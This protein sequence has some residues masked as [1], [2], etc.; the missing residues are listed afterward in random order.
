MSQCDYFAI[1]NRGCLPC[2]WLHPLKD[3]EQDRVPRWRGHV[4]PAR[5][6]W[7]AVQKHRP[8]SPDGRIFDFRTPRHY[9][10]GGNSGQI[11]CP[12][13]QQTQ[14]FPDAV[15]T[16]G[17][18]CY[19]LLAGVF[20]WEGITIYVYEICNGLFYCATT[21]IYAIVW[22]WAPQTPLYQAAASWGLAGVF[23]MGLASLGLL[24]QDNYRRERY[25]SR[26]GSLE[27][28][29]SINVSTWARPKSGTTET[30]ASFLANASNALL[31]DSALDLP[32]T[33]VVMARI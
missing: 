16:G 12:G 5:A 2:S 19:G 4:F 3:P 18:I 10:G 24:L 26:Y 23:I 29:R 22:S 30:D 1:E 14:R 13:E 7:P 28:M 33:A 21:I 31:K 6:A 27:L 20:W 11:P 9:V 32:I 8:L 25:G 17:A 15:L